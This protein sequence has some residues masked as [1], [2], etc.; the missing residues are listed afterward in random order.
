M[1]GK[2]SELKK[3]IETFSK[4]QTPFKRSI[5][6]SQFSTW[7]K[8]PHR[9]YLEYIKKIKKDPNIYFVIGNSLH[10]VV[11][12]YI[13]EMYENSKK[14]ASTLNLAEKFETRLLNE[15]KKT[16]KEYNTHFST[17]DELRSISEDVA[18]SLNYLQKNQNKLFS[19]RSVELLGIEIPL[20]I[21]LPN[22]IKYIGYI[23]FAVYYKESNIVKIYDIKYS[24]KMG[25]TDY[26]KKDEIKQ[27]QLILYKEFFSQLFGI[28]KENIQIEFLIIKRKIYEN[29][30]FP[31]KYYQL[32]SPASGKNKINKILKNL[33]EFS[34]SVYDENGEL[35]PQDF[36]KEITDGCKFCPFF[37]DS[38]LCDRSEY[39]FK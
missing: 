21:D 17:P 32:Y 10:S 9:F 2:K 19:S 35:I 37:N 15:Y 18:I 27:S 23:D 30:E 11:Q 25:W 33:Q 14:S 8:C 5:S 4:T 29:L 1:A 22:N 20:R 28:D 24:N 36:K 6:Y 7:K 34:T 16:Y 38:N 39:N 31:Q 3:K 26:D 12:E 13:T